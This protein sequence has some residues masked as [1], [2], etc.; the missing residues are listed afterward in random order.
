MFAFCL[1]LTRQENVIAK[2]LFEVETPP[3]LEDITREELV[4]NLKR[5]STKLL[6]L[7]TGSIQLHYD[8]DL[9]R[10]LS[11]KTATAVYLLLRYPIPRPRA[12]LGHEHFTRLTNAINFLISPYPI[13]T[14]R[15]FHVSAAGSD[16][17]DMRRL[18]DEIGKYT[19]LEDESSGAGDLL[20]RIRRAKSGWEVLLR[21]SPR[22]LSTRDW[23][24][25]NMEGALNGPVARALSIL[26]DVQSHDH[27]LNLMCGSG[28]ILIERITLQ[29]DA[30]HTIGLDFDAAALECARQNLYAAGVS[31][32]ARLINGNADC[33]PIENQ[34]IDVVVADLPFGQLIG[35][36]QINERL[37]P[38]M[39]DEVARITKANARFVALT[40]ELR[41]LRRCLR[42]D[43]NW[44]IESERKIGLRGLHPRIFV[45][46]KR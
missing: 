27:F 46:R 39:L 42:H 20:I 15:S 38:R 12:L 28:S 23:R 43:I 22:P 25:C 33:I 8:G 21:L 45:L 10:L 34:S 9:K 35:S 5:N 7:D 17:K 36:H 29:S 44:N 30:I 16:S 40:H 26:S 19:G 1:C 3:G 6:K 4:G 32:D 11:L 13:N 41:L 24:V 14:F 18:R 2:Q 37:Y 31:N